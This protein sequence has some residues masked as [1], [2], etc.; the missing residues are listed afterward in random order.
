M[1]QTGL[2]YIYAWKCHKETPCV[3]ILKKQ[4]CHFLSFLQNQRTGEWS[5]SCLAGGTTRRGR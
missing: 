4:N 3:A 1:N 5:R 2:Q